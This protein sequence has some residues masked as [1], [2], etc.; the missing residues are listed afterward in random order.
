MTAIKSDPQQRSRPKQAIVLVVEDDD[1]RYAW[2]RAWLAEP[3]I[4]LLR[5]TTGDAALRSVEDRYDLILLDHDL[6]KHHPLGRLARI[7]GSAIVDRLVSTRANRETRIVIH[8]M[9]PAARS[10]MHQRLLA[11]GYDAEL[12]PFAE[13]TPAWA[14]DLVGKLIEEWESEIS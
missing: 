14:R 5:V 2:F 8:S 7:D 1:N 13:W 9:N 10:R 4:R 6:D 12:K 11:N 3:R